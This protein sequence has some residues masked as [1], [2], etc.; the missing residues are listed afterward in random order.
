VSLG[1]EERASLPPF[2]YGGVMLLCG[3]YPRER[4]RVHEIFWEQQI[5][6]FVAEQYLV[7]NIYPYLFI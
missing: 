4:G 6:F 7:L 3:L 2:P 1:D 5:P